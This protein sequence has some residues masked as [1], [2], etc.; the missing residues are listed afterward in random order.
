MAAV[1]TKELL[2]WN[3]IESQGDRK[4]ELAIVTPGPSHPVFTPWQIGITLQVFDLKDWVKNGALGNSHL[5]LCYVTGKSCVG[6]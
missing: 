5:V 2:D 4:F 1:N 6:E 3:Q